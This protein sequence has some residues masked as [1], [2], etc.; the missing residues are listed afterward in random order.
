[1]LQFFRIFGINLRNK[2]YETCFQR[3]DHRRCI[4]SY[5]ARANRYFSDFFY[6]I[7]VV[8]KSLKL[9]TSGTVAF[10]FCDLEDVFVLIV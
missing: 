8:F 10:N 7:C 2:S 1:M 6:R 3:D 5:S 9:G 4:I